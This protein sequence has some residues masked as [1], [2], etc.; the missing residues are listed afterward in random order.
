LVT[1]EVCLLRPKMILP[2]RSLGMNKLS[3]N[4]PLMLKTMN[5]SHSEKKKKLLSMRQPEP[6]MSLKVK[7]MFLMT[8]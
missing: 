6:S 5:Y 3:L 1:T 4:N 8:C 2:E 7:L